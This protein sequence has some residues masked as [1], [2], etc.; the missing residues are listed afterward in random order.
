MVAGGWVIDLFIG[1]ETRSHQD[2]EIAIPRKEQLQLQTYLH[3]W[4]L[5]Y[6]VD[7]TFFP[8]GT[9]HVPGVTHP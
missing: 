4:N 7:G 9:R 5:R 8:L 3:D 6:V 2:I 1:R